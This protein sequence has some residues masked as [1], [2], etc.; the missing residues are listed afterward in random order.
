MS[1][2]TMNWFASKQ[3]TSHVHVCVVL[4]IVLFKNMMKTK[5]NLAGLLLRS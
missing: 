3:N 2:C 4:S 1:Q 5:K